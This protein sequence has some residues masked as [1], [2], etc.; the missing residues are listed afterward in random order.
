MCRLVGVVASETTNFRFCLHDAPRSLAVLSPDHPDGWGVA[1]HD[2]ERWDIEKQPGCAHGDLQYAAVSAERH[3][4]VLIAHVRKRTVGAVGLDNTHPFERG[5]WTFAHNGTIEDL[6]FLRA[7]TS[8]LRLAEIEGQ[9]DSELFFAYLL[10]AMD[11]RPDAH[12]EALTDALSALVAREGVAANMVL[13]DGNVL[14]A[15]RFGRTLFTL[16]REPGD[17]VRTERTSVETLATLET[18]WTARRTATLIASEALSDEPWEVVANGTLLRIDRS[19]L[20]TLRVV[21]RTTADAP[22]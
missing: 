6:P 19:D 5:P 15:H 22:E 13:S 1:V 11:A 20:P 21:A 7:G 2:G 8:A 4:V 9:T 16:Q 14:Y 3:G 18:A 17:P 12:D 10:T